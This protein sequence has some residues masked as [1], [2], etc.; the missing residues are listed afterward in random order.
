MDRPIV[1]VGIAG[2]DFGV[3]GLAVVATELEAD[4]TAGQ[5]LA[6]FVP[7]SPVFAVQPI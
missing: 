2:A 3:A 1:R 7:H 4:K 5:Q 6:L